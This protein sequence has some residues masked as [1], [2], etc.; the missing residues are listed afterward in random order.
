MMPGD[1]LVP[2]FSVSSVTGD[3]IEQLR[4][5]IAKLD[6]RDNTSRYLGKR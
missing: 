1:R 3:G 2:I 5:F 6:N 4:K